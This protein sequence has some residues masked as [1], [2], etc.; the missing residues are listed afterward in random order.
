MGE[1]KCVDCPNKFVNETKRKISRCEECREKR[2]L[3]TQEK[4]EKVKS[5]GKENSDNETTNSVSS[6]SNSGDVT[7]FNKESNTYYGL[8][9]CQGKCKKFWKEEHMKESI[10]LNCT[11]KDKVGECIECNT[12]TST[13]YCPKHNKLYVRDYL[14]ETFGEDKKV[15]SNFK[16]RGCVNLVSEG[17]TCSKCRNKDKKKANNKRDNI[18]KKNEELS[19]N[20]DYRFCHKCGDKYNKFLT[21]LNEVSSFC[22]TCSEVRRRADQ[23]R[24]EKNKK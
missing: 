1:Q 8:T 13:K 20:L 10:C 17:K 9:K 23:K 2:R 21:S 19:D 24:N 22:A 5:E 12:K 4:R 11:S 16:D 14:L 15:C 18:Q 7:F 6:E 3:K